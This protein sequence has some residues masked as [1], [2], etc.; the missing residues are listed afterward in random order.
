MPKLL[1]HFSLP[2]QAWHHSESVWIWI[3]SPCLIWSFDF[4][5]SSGL[6]GQAW[7]RQNSC[8]RDSSGW[9]ARNF[10]M[11]DKAAFSSIILLD[12]VLGWVMLGWGI[13]LFLWLRQKSRLILVMARFRLHFLLS[14]KMHPGLR[15]LMLIEQWGRCSRFHFSFLSDEPSCYIAKM[16]FWSWQSWINILVKD[17]LLSIN[18]DLCLQLKIIHTLFTLQML[19]CFSMSL[20]GSFDAISSFPFSLECYKLFVYGTFWL[21]YD[22]LALLNQQL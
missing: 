14:L 3:C 22:K 10:C 20:K 13:G 2:L 5:C 15:L 6:E 7:Q 17:L 12:W 19:G 9:R 11:M 8:I 21:C 4:K 1:P 16:I 18:I